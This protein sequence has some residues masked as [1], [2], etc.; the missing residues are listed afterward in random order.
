[1]SY[2]ARAEG[3]VN[4][5]NFMGISFLIF[6][7]KNILK[8]YF[9][10]IF[11]ILHLVL[12]P[13]SWTYRS[14]FFTSKNIL[15]KYFYNISSILHLVLTPTSWTYRS[16]FFTSKNILKKYFYNF[17]LYITS[18]FDTNF[19]GIGCARGVVVIVVGNGHGDTSLNPG[20][21]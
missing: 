9:Y 5:T 7:S 6:T 13:T 18:G 12:T 16:L 2:P 11:S 19:M 21:D 17:F 15:K 1:M 4:I 14:L 8:E 20:R 10:N 3:L